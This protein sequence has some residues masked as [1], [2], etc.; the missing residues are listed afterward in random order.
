MTYIDLSCCNSHI[1]QISDGCLQLVHASISRH[2]HVPTVCD[3]ERSVQLCYS[4]GAKS[5]DDL[6]LF[7]AH[8][9]QGSSGRDR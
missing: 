3:C 8:V 1:L 6:P 9:S 7:D 2:V 5:A 4:T